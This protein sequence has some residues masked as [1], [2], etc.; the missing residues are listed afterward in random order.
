MFHTPHQCV[1]M[2]CDV[3][4]LLHSLY[5]VFN[6]GV[7]LHL[8]VFCETFCEP[9][10]CKAKKQLPLIYTKKIFEHFQIPK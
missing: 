5:I 9:K 4:I 8:K 3:C 2:Q 10:W 7:P 1:V 6:T